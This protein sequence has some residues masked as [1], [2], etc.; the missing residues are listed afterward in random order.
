MSKYP[1]FTGPDFIGV[2]PEKTGTTWVDKQLRQHDNIWLP[3]VKELRF[4]WEYQTFKPDNLANRIRHRNSWHAV[5]YK[6]YAKQTAFQLIRNPVKALTSKRNQLRWDLS[7]LAGNHDF[8]WYK[9]T[10][11]ADFR[12]LTG[13]ISPQY[14]FL[15]ENT[16]QQMASAFSATQIIITLRDPVDWLWSFTRMIRKN[17]DLAKMYGEVNTFVETK[18]RECS[19]SQ[20]VKHWYSHFGEQRVK[21]LFYEDLCNSPWEYYTEICQFLGIASLP[22][23]KNNVTEYVNQGIE[24]QKPDWFVEKVNEGWMEDIKKLTQMVPNVPATWLT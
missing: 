14:F 20:S 11:P 23:L 16:I 5:Q 22:E 3:P 10:F 17:G 1:N 4:F 8:D 18:M 13:E 24:E 19:F 9:S 15:R 21:I 2:G 12:G 6:D 7:Y